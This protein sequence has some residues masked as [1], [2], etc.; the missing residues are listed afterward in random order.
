MLVSLKD[1]EQLRNY[2]SNPLDTRYYAISIIAEADRVQ[3]YRYWADSTFE[4]VRDYYQ[5]MVEGP[6]Y[7]LYPQ[8]SEHR[9]NMDPCLPVP[10]ALLNVV[11]LD[12]RGTRLRLITP[13]RHAVNPALRSALNMGVE[14]WGTPTSP[15]HE[16]TGWRVLDGLDGEY[17]VLDS[18]CIPWDEAW[19]NPYSAVVGKVILSS[20]SLLPATALGYHLPLLRNTLLDTCVLQHGE[21]A[22]VAIFSSCFAFPQTDKEHEL[23]ARKAH[24]PFQLQASPEVNEMLNGLD[25]NIANFFKF[26]TWG[27]WNQR[28]M[29]IL[30][31]NAPDYLAVDPADYKRVTFVPHAKVAGLLMQGKDP[32]TDGSRQST[33]WGKLGKMFVNP[34]VCDLEPKYEEFS[35]RM[36]AA[37]TDLYGPEDSKP[38]LLIVRGLDIAKAYNKGAVTGVGTNSTG[39]KSCMNSKPDSFFAVY[40]ENPDQVAMLICRDRQDGT[41][42]GRALLWT[43]VHG[44]KFLDR[45]YVLNPVA[46]ARMLQYAIKLGY[47]DIWTGLSKSQL[48]RVDVQL[49]NPY[50]LHYPWIDS[51]RYFHPGTGTLCN[52]Y[53]SGAITVQCTSGNRLAGHNEVHCAQSRVLAPK[54]KLEQTASGDYAFAQYV[55]TLRSGKKELENRC[56]KD[57]LEGGLISK[58]ESVEVFTGHTTKLLT[59]RGNPAVCAT[60]LDHRMYTK[61]QLVLSP[62][63]GGYIFKETAVQQP[64]GGWCL[65]QTV[66][67]YQAMRSRKKVNLARRVTTLEQVEQLFIAAAEFAVAA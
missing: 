29:F 43:D 5:K 32:W 22:N 53:V 45:R 24:V 64:D 35:S 10:A 65:P 19:T 30:G 6:C 37:A 40:C 31:Q 57:Q 48:I 60:V 34:A 49:A 44:N 63:D 54:S 51:L 55:L 11:D 16:E 2:F 3:D 58:A 8:L 50:H 62:L 59:S 28:N 14:F 25:Q 27:T 13:I 36:V 66:A 23:F 47:V 61:D 4:Y 7:L 18:S 9:N 12:A 15:R 52:Q 46:E 42:H 41:L 21:Y 38:E 39:A 26:F 56:V 33:T 67:R 17:S 20:G 1:H